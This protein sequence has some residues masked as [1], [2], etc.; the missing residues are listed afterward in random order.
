MAYYLSEQRTTLRKR[1][2]SG[3]WLMD[4][5]GKQTELLLRLVD[6][7]MSQTEAKESAPTWLRAHK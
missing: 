2:A 6:N 7:P 5:P 4:T 3:K 1:G